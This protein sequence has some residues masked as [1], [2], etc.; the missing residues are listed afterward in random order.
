[1]SSMNV[2]LLLHSLLFFLSSSVTSLV[3][4]LTSDVVLAYWVSVIILANCSLNFYV[5]CLSGRQFR[6]GLKRIAEHHIRHI[7]KALTP[8]LYSYNRREH[9]YKILKNK[10]F[11]NPVHQI[12]Q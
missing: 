8:N 5:Y 6:R 1:M 12:K 2:V 9:Q 7:R 10:I 3:F 11:N 4:F